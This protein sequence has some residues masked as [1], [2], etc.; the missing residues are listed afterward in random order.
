[1]PYD[2][3]DA[4]CACE[5]CS[6]GPREDPPDE[7]CRG[8]KCND[9]E[10]MR[11]GAATA[12]ADPDRTAWDAEY[13]WRPFQWTCDHCQSPYLV[14]LDDP[15]LVADT[16]TLCPECTEAVMRGLEAMRRAGLAVY[17]VGQAYQTDDGAQQAETFYHE[18]AKA[19]R[20]DG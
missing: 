18:L 17:G 20:D 11:T 15:M 8:C 4:N 14:G 5:N 10:W 3:P 16:V 9:P 6:T 2:T 19:G 7:F 13:R 1:M 12:I